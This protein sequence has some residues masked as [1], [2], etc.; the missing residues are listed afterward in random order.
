MSFYHT[1]K[2]ILFGKRTAAFIGLIYL[3]AMFCTSVANAQT[4]ITLYNNFAG[5]VN[6]TVIGGSLRTSGNTVDPTA[7][8]STDTSKLSIP[9]GASV[10]GAYLYW[11]GSGASADNAVT[12][13]TPYGSSSVSATRTFTEQNN[14]GGWRYWFGGFADVTSFV[15]S[16]PN[17]TTFTFGDL[18]IDNTGI[19][20]SS[21]AAVSGW[22]MVVVYSLSSE[23]KKSVNIYDGFQIFKGSQITVTPNNFY[24]P[25]ALVSGKMTHITFEGDK[26]NSTSSGGYNE[27]VKFNGTSLTDADN[28]VNNQFGSMSNMFTVDSTF[29]VDIDSYDITSYLSPADT[30]A[31]SDY[32]S[33]GDLVILMSEI[34]SIADT[35][36]SDIQ[37]VKTHSGGSIVAGNNVTY[38]ITT[39]NNGPDTTG[40]IT[41]FDSLRTGLTF[42]SS[43]F[44]GWTIDSSARPK[45]KWTHAGVHPP[46]W[47]SA[48]TVTA[49]LTAAS[50]PTQY[51]TSY[52][53]SPQFDRKPW[54]NANTDS[55]TILTPIFLTSTKSYSDLNGG[56]VRPGDTLLY[57]IGVANSGNYPATNI[58]VIDSLPASMS[59]VPGS[60]SPSA[61][62]TGTSSTGQVITYNNYA[63]PLNVSGSTN[64]TF[65][66]VVDSSILGGATVT[67]VARVR[68]ATI[69]QRVTA[70]FVPVNA[71]PLTVSKFQYPPG[72]GTGAGDTV[73]YYI[74]V[75]NASMSATSTNTIVVDTIPEPSGT[76]ANNP[77]YITSGTVPAAVLTRGPNVGDR[78]TILTWTLGTIAPGES[79]TVRFKTRISGTLADGNFVTNRAFATNDQGRRDSSIHVYRKS[80]TFTGWIT[81]TRYILPGDPIYYSLY[82]AD[83]NTNNATPQGLTLFDTNRVSSERDS[84]W[85]LESAA[86]SGLFT[87]M[88]RTRYNLTAGANLDDTI[89]VRPGD[90]IRVTYNDVADSAGNAN[91]WRVFYTKVLNGHA[92]VL[93]GT[94][95]ILPT[96][97]ITYTVNDSDL[98]RN[99]LLAE[100]YTLRDSNQATGEIENLLFTETGLNTGIF[101]SS[102]STVFGTVSN[103]NNNGSFAVQKGDTVTL[104][105]YDTVVVNGSNGGLKTW[106]TYVRG[107]VTATISASSIIY[108]GDSVLVSITDND[109]N[110]DTT[111]VQSYT[112]RDSSVTT[113]EV[114]YFTVTETGVNTGIFTKKIPTQ[115]RTTDSTSNDGIFNVKAGDSL[116][117]SY[118][119]TLLTNGGPGGIMNAVTRV[120]GGATASISATSP[121]IPGDSVTITVTDADLNRNITSVETYTVK[122]S[123]ISTG[124]VES[125]TIT[126]TGANTGIFT[127][128]IGTIFGLTAGTNND[129]RFN[130]KTGDTLRASYRDTMLTNGGP[131]GTITALTIVRGGVTALL[132]AATPIIPGDSILITITD[133]DL[134]RDTTSVQ[135]YTVKDSSIATG[136]VES[137]TITETGV[138]TGI[139]TKK[140]GTVFGLTA[141]TNNDGR[142]NVKATDTLRVTY[143]DTLQANGGSATLTS[144]T[145]V[146][147]GTTAV[148]AA[149]TPIFP[150]DSILITIT[151]ADLNRDSTTIQMYTVKD[152][153]IATGEV[154]SFTITE[155]AVNSG[156]FTKW[157]R[158]VFGLTAGTNNDGIFNVKATDTLRVTYRDTLQTNGGTA[159]LTAFTRVNGGA[160]ATVTSTT[161][162]IPTDSVLI[163]ITDADLNRNIA[164]IETYTVKDSSISTGEV[165]SFTITETG[166][167]TGIFTKKLAT[168]FG[169][170]AGTNN[171]GIFNVKANDTL[172]VTYRDSLQLN[173]GAATITAIT[174]VNGGTTATLTAATP[175][176]PADSVLI[177]I[178]DADLNRNIA[179]A[180][181]YTVKDSSVTT[182]EVESFTITETGVNTGIFTKK[183]ATIFGLTAGTNNDGRFNV[184]AGDTL[185][186]TYRDSLQLNGGAATLTAFTRVNGG[187]TATI[188]ATTPIIPVDSVLITIT[189]ADLN[190]NIALAETYTVKDSSIATGEV[191]SFTITETGVN[192]GIFTKKIATI[193]GLTA[194]TNN[195]GRF[196]VKA[197]DT[198]RVTYRDSLQLNGGAATL[199]AFTRVNGGTTATISAT[200]P[201]IPADSV[202]I[203][204]TDAD[205]NRNIALAETYTVKDSSIATGEVESFTITET[206]VNTGIFT[207]KIATVFGL[208][209]GTNNDGIFNV[210]AT[211]TLRV[212]YRDTLQSNGGSATL[213]AFTRVN[214]GTNATISATTPIF[215][216]DS[217]LITITDA[218]LNR[219][220]AS[221]ETYT[222][223]DSSVATGEVESFTITETGVNTGIFTKKLGTVFGL[224][225]GTNNDGRF[226]VKAG[227]T[228]RVTY[229][230]TLQ[231]NGGSATLTAFTRVNGGTTATISATT[232]IFPADSV[233]ITITD[234]DLNRNIALAETYT[235]KDSSIATGEVESFTITETGANTGIFTKKLGTVFG[236]TAGTNNDGRFNVKSG[237][238]LRVTYRDTLQLNGGSAT[239]T[240]FTRVN[241]GTTATI[242]ATTPIIPADSVLITITDAD[243]NRN[244]A[245]AETYTVKDSSIATGE[246]ESFTI[247]E[248]GV[249]TGIFT[250][251]LGTIFG[252][253][254]GTNNDG[255][256][257]VKAGDTLRVTYR[258]TLQ[259]NGGSATL[260]AFTRVN[261]GV[262]ATITATTPIIPADSVLI[263]ITDADLN[264][265]IGSAETYTVKDS[266]IATGEVESFTITETGVNTGIFTKKLATIFG[267][268]AGTNNDGRFNVKAGDT[269][270]VTYRDTLQTNGG[271][272]T[273]TAFTRVNGGTTATITATTPI[274]PADSLLITITDADLNRNIALAET[275]TVKDSSVATGEVE[276][277]TIT[278][279]GVNTGIFTKRLGT[280]FGLTAGTN[281][282]GRFNVKSGDTLRVTYRD[283]LQLNGGSATL[284]AFTRVNGGTTATIT[285][286]TPIF[287]ADSLLIT[288]T[289]AD[290]NKNI[291]L[292]E[293]Y[294][295]KDSS[296]AT[297]EVESFTITE[298]G[299]NTG[300]FT[301]KLG[302]V[303]GLTAGTNNDGR[304]NVKAGDTLRVTYRDTM[305]TNGGS[306][307]LT[308]FTRV[309][310]GTTATV[311]ATTPIIPADSVLITITD[312]DLNKNIALAETYTVKDSS[313]ATGEVESFTI[314]ETGVN[315]GI[316]TKK[317][318]TIFGL[319]AGT[320]NDGRF[321]VKAGDTLR[322]T[323]R[324]TMQTN[325]GSATLTAFTRVNGGTTAT[326]TATTPIYP[327]DSLLITIT[328]ADLNRNIASAE[329]YTV[330]D[331]SI[332]TGEVESFTITETGV[333][334]GIFTKRLGTVFGITAGT[335][336]DG[337]FNVKAG[338][339]LRVT[340]RDSLQLN[341]GAS[342]LTAFTRVNGGITATLVSGSAVIAANDSSTFTLTDGDL[343]RNSG[344]AETYSFTVRSSTGETEAMTFTESGVNTGIFTK[345]VPTL[346]GTTPGANNNGTFAV[347]PNDTISVSY[348]D[349]LRVLGD[350]ATISAFFRIG[351]VNFSTSSK[352][353]QD[354]NGG[355]VKP[356][357]TLQYTVR[358]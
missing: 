18:T 65:R 9:S 358:V 182:G 52:A 27:E 21:Q 150:A 152:S 289:D 236:L 137:F 166:V 168:V 329:T 115:F 144:F 174:R 112:V 100:T 188:T 336:N 348:K 130:V 214:G 209:A 189:D 200:T 283:T 171:D 262:T 244:I 206:G 340:Y 127:K 304:F 114:E 320:N 75:T 156:I 155:T 207:K 255:R 3:A 12:L 353:Y 82:D 291:A 50:Y 216:A 264:R 66:A 243:L 90:S 15:Q 195:D 287:P 35:A 309:N 81:G 282:D 187:T 328:D 256:F 102:V 230:D 17:N 296:V 355:F 286:T 175:I 354:L 316:F 310:G 91:S 5:K 106:K 145:R 71:P 16:T 227:D 64:F 192:T 151:D 181:T 352:S 135:T 140:L 173:G 314:T 76:T 249:N 260:T 11:A 146:N 72:T 67:N 85:M 258:D 246:V 298:T 87:G 94:S 285:A 109:L 274:F 268:T 62:Y 317:L 32:S 180:E 93:S 299:A 197:G 101:T 125:F 210:K 1:I 43:S 107:G 26:E 60:F 20:S 4:P 139:F 92:A 290:L 159:T 233:L 346:F 19:Y 263:T 215:P 119:D 41:L 117:F 138:N 153:S 103:G 31:T 56:S 331:S 276:S 303:F 259:S 78:D 334:T 149:T 190:R 288:I 7:L 77:F 203:T 98:N 225:A 349:S 157:L 79:D 307:T 199:T 136:E 322:V 133:N 40:T 14:N 208:T 327:R 241:G 74:V 213:T 121:I 350:S 80:N 59:V 294:T 337:R 323:Y 96:Q 284:T 42:V 54:N 257:N 196:N 222:V 201:I 325:G 63:G 118:Y 73:Q 110:R 178:T 128:K 122:D 308:A 332:A 10:V 269:L 351:S 61:T 99:R 204:I 223:K 23:V 326:I 49:Y 22:A 193:F 44:S 247:T 2:N 239:L 311:N 58:S 324:D 245:L 46:G 356:P 198:L 338:D 38:T 273:L 242:S 279:T 231:S 333:N 341:G 162:I 154:E 344:S 104:K 163:T 212:T 221:I 254:A 120:I 228:L 292:A 69:D 357:D 176:Y 335:N 319:T 148:V 160:T 105:Y 108:P 345:R 57:T 300:I 167:N 185:R 270:R 232:P 191:E 302:T 179:V 219:N 235:V 252:L 24:V 297:G 48:I 306:A 280:V 343:N 37:T 251:K 347:Q 218:D 217:V 30:Q 211:D 169:L 271:S 183:I 13:T 55:F 321:N 34:I 29:G 124:E 141:G 342:T 315:T 330:K 184:K 170:T 237:D 8:R 313:V 312:A 83:L 277:F 265:N 39:Y 70:S 51:N 161:P 132:T 238:T 47:S 272:A 224:T 89:Y 28:P 116:R 97:T 177:T 25:Y 126:E 147:G 226:N 45:Y 318:G 240:A 84:A 266:S 142:F 186:V 220:I 123:S 293:T 131:G 295:I 113:R 248:T 267:L 111:S 68:A 33:G 158:T 164:S 234:A 278:E 281:N 202:L 6:Y 143:R 253:T 194:G 88:V 36:N 305:Q 339:T 229:R 86:N 134:N 53:S 95:I 129:G 275:Y 172:R 261:G 165:E 301:K 205:L 250:K